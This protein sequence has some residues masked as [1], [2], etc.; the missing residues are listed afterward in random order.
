MEKYSINSKK[1]IVNKTVNEMYSCSKR[2]YD[3]IIN[4]NEWRNPMEFKIKKD[5]HRI[6]KL[7]YLKLYKG[8]DFMFEG[9]FSKEC[10]YPKEAVKEPGDKNKLFGVSLERL[11]FPKKIQPADWW[12]LAPWHW[13]SIRLAWRPDFN[14]KGMIN[15]FP[16]I[17]DAGTRIACPRLFSIKS[18]EKFVIGVESFNDKL[19]TEYKIHAYTNNRKYIDEYC[20]E[21]L[22]D[23]K[24][25]YLPPYFGGNN[26]SPQDMFIYINII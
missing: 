22:V 13:N 9:A 14:N 24:G 15:V 12:S 11:P 23:P 3:D 10:W 25:Y 2:I 20:F 5:K 7:F 17:Y 18:E 26:V 4:D 1:F 19:S 21:Y 6:D 8:E 16:Y